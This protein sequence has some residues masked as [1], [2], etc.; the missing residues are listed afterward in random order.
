MSRAAQGTKRHPRQMPKIRWVL[1]FQV[2]SLGIFQD[3]VTG[4]KRRLPGREDLGV[5]QAQGEEPP[6]VWKDAEG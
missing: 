4:G 6:A 3:R 5:T 2:A 1:S